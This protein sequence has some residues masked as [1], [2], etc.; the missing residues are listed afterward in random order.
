MGA[1][2]PNRLFLVDPPLL[3]LFVRHDLLLL[4]PQVNLLFRAFDTV[5][6]VADVSTDIDGIVPT[7]S[8]RG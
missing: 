2:R 1:L 3:V 6:A 5:R 4:E 7:D 8:P